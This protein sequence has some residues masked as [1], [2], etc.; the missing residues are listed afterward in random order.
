MKNWVLMIQDNP[1]LFHIYRKLSSIVKI[2]PYVL[3][4][5]RYIEGLEPAIK[6]GLDNLKMVTLT[7]HDI[8]EI[9]LQEEVIQSA[10]E[11]LTQFEGERLCLGLKYKKRIAA[12]TWCDLEKCSFKNWTLKLNADEAYLFDARTFKAFRGMNLA[13]YLRYQTYKHLFSQG[14][15]RYYSLSIPTNTS[16]FR[17]KEKLGAKRLQKNVYISFLQRYHMHIMVKKY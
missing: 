3:L 12:Y 8:P 16:S 13:P 11:L 1:T 5:E 14:R 4:E 7:R 10:E 2:L 9:I 17:F 15:T 6:P